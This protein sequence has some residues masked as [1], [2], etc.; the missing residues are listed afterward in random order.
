MCIAE[1]STMPSATPLLFTIAA[2]SSVMRMN[3][4][5]FLVLNQRYSVAVFIASEREAGVGVDVERGRDAGAIL[6]QAG[7]RNHR[8]IIGRE[9]EARDEDR[10]APAISLSDGVRAQP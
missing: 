10:K 5:R 6:A 4:W 8:G 7:G 3:S 1:T 9:R 2:T